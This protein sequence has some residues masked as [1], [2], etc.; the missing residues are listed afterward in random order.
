[1]GDMK[2]IAERILQASANFNTA[3]SLGSFIGS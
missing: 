2:D 1:M 3:T